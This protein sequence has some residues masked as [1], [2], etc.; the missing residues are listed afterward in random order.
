M[1]ASKPQ[2]PLSDLMR[3]VMADIAA[4]RGG[5]HGCNG[6]S[7]HGGRRGTLVGLATRGLIDHREEL[8]AAGNEWLALEAAKKRRPEADW[9]HA[10]EGTTHVIRQPGSDRVVWVRIVDRRDAF[11]RWPGAKNWRPSTSVASTM[12]SGPYIEPRPGPLAVNTV[13][14]PTK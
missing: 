14:A 5:Y 8:T 3:Q 10:P 6:R 9:S 13:N 7:E 4:G 12:L 1:R 11:W 2:R